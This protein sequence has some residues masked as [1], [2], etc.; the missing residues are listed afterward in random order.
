M[1]IRKHY[2]ELKVFRK[3]GRRT[4][5]H[6]LKTYQNPLD[7]GIWVVLERKQMRLPIQILVR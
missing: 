2:N 1:S 3:T 5:K 7:Y 4:I 6:D